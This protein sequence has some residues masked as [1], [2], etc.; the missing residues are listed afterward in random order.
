MT[1][2]IIGREMYGFFSFRTAFLIYTGDLNN[3]GTVA[4]GERPRPTC[5]FYR[6]QKRSFETR[7]YQQKGYFYLRPCVG[8]KF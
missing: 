1:R 7:G 3:L 4:D 8:V 6:I 5:T 2:T